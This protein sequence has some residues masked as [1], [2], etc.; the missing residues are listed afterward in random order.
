M[1]A[2]AVS[3]A[4]LMRIA[5]W[6]AFEFDTTGVEDDHAELACQTIKV[7]LAHIKAVDPA[8]ANGGPA[9]TCERAGEESGPFVQAWHSD[10]C[11][12][13]QVPLSRA[14]GPEDK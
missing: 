14:C 1:E 9:C 3:P 2:K 5:F 7:L 13:N 8:F 6:N 10:T 11:A 12:L 4:A